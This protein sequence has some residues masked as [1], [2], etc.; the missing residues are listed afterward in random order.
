MIHPENKAGQGT[1]RSYA[2]GFALSLLFTFAAYAA[3]MYEMTS[4]WALDTILAAL[5]LAQVWTLLFFFLDLG[6]E[7]KPRWNLL[8]FLFMALV[9]FILV[10][11]SIWIMHHLNYNLMVAV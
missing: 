6:K 10:V 7:S 1:F 3:A 11:G 9:T 5:G 2:L 4:T 8:V